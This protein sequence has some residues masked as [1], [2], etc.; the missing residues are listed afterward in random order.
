[1]TQKK[2][3]APKIM[4]LARDRMTEPNFVRQHWVISLPHGIPYEN[5]FVPG[6]W[7]LLSPRLTRGD[8]ISVRSDDLTLHAE[9]VAVAVDRTRSLAEVR[10]LS[11]VKVKPA[12]VTEAA[13]GGY[14]AVDLGVSEKWAIRRNADGMIV[15]K[16]IQTFDAAEARI[17]TEF[18]TR[19]QEEFLTIGGK[20]A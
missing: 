20:A 7:R 5:V 17:K 19:K 8:I 2:T 11:C 1:M 4:P 3:E 6:F 15:A 9:L 10:E 16:G 13:F 18:A 12:T 14:S